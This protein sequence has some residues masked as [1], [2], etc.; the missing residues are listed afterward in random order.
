MGGQQESEPQH[1]EG[2]FGIL[3]DLP[4]AAAMAQDFDQRIDNMV[5]HAQENS[6]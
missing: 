1:A 3:N 5:K 6:G 4:M 2:Q